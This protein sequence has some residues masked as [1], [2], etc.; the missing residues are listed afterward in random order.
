MFI[1]RGKVTTNDGSA[2]CQK[3]QLCGMPE[4]LKQ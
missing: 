3:I 2:V 4:F 1:Y